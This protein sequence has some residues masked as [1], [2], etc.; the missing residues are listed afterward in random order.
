MTTIAA[1]MVLQ[2]SA[3]V[4]IGL[5]EGIAH[6]N[7]RLVLTML[8]WWNAGFF[9]VIVITAACVAQGESSCFACPFDC[10]YPPLFEGC[11]LIVVVPAL[12]MAD[13][14]PDHTWVCHLSPTQ[15]NL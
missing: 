6:V 14:L 8:A 4:A 11:L 3:T 1:R 13:L 2:V 15:D 5:V 7:W 12:I 10:N 9:L